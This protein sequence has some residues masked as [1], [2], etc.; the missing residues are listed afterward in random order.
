[1]K[2]V[3]SYKFYILFAIGLVPLSMSWSLPLLKTLVFIYD[4][5]LIAAA[6]VD[7]LGSRKRAAGLVSNRTFDRRSAIGDPTE[8]T[9][10]FENLSDAAFDLRVK[11]EKDYQECRAL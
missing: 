10:H 1:M 9:V 4:G 2:F 6:A 7:Y 8:V 3:F 11:D 5:L